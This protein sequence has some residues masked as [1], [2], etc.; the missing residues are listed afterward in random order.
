MTRQGPVFNNAPDRRAMRRFVV[1]LPALVRISGIPY[2]FNTCT[3]N[4]SAS[5]IFFYIDRWMSTDAR[6]E[7]TVSLPAQVTL[8]EAVQVRL[9]AL[10]LRIEPQGPERTGVAAAIEAY[11]FLR[12][13]PTPDGLAKLQARWA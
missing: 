4:V 5:G 3:E 2:E 12:S 10:V 11:E 1:R 8:T 7:V 6:V 9:H 13:D